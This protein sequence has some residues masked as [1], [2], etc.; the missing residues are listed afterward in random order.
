MK[1]KTRLALAIFALV[2]VLT[3]SFVSAFS[4]IVNFGTD[5]IEL[6]N[7]AGASHVYPSNWYCYGYFGGSGSNNDACACDD[8]G[9]VVCCDSIKDDGVWVK[10]MGVRSYANKITCEASCIPVNGGWSSSVVGSWSTCNS[11]GQRF[12]I[13]NQTCNNP[14]PNSC[15]SNC[16]TTAG[17]T[18]GGSIQTKIETESCVPI[19]V[20]VQE[21]CNNNIDDD[22]DGSFDEGCPGSCINGSVTNYSL[23]NNTCS[24]NTLLSNF[25]YLLCQ[26]NSWV[27]LFNQSSTNC[28]YGCLNGVCLNNNT[29]S[30][31]LFVDIASPASRTYDYSQILLNISSNGTNV[32]YNYNGTNITY[33]GALYLYLS[34]GNYNLVAWANN[35]TGA[36]VSDSVSFSVDL[37]GGDDDDDNNDCHGCNDCEP[38][39][40]GTISIDN[41]NETPLVLGDYSVQSEEDQMDLGTFILFLVGGI[42]L[43]MIVILVIV[44][45]RILN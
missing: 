41:E 22:C 7:V 33:N 25:S 1:N 9:Y 13:L 18:R 2:L 36:I 11:S 40:D 6:R 35:S 3:F 16:A 21:I 31:G 23:I 14:S 5:G 38:V 30:T 12:R 8:N 17:W 44:L 43:V 32:W 26:S 10:N 27:S 24:G 20:P 28:L 19:C 4:N 42:I 34:E 45:V 29:N 15:G 39:E 37:N